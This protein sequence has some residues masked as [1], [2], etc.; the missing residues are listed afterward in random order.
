MGGVTFRALADTMEIVN[1]SAEMNPTMESNP[2]EIIYYGHCE[3]I[4]ASAL[5]R[6]ADDNLLYIKQAWEL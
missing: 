2:R 1:P 3:K 4:G 5:K 6:Q